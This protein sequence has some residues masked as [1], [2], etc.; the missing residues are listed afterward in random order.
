MHSFSGVEPKFLQILE[1][2]RSD[3]K[4]YGRDSLYKVMGYLPDLDAHWEGIWD[5]RPRVGLVFPELRKPRSNYVE[6]EEDI[7]LVSGEA[8]E[9]LE[10]LLSNYMESAR[11][12]AA[13][14]RQPLK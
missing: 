9:R 11:A 4:S 1:I 7:V 13:R 5:A 6:A 12:S 10:S 2:K 3:D 14:I 8:D